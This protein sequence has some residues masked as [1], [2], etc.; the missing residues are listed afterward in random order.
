LAAL[1]IVYVLGGGDGFNQKARDLKVLEKDVCIFCDSD[2]D[3]K[4]GDPDKEKL[5]GMGICIFDCEIGNNIEKQVIS[6]LPW[7]GV[8]ELY[9]YIKK[10]KKIN[11]FDEYIEQSSG[12]NFTNSDD[13]DSREAF[14]LA[15][16]KEGN[17]FFKRIDRGEFFGDICLKYKEELSGK[18]FLRKQM[19][20]IDKWIDYGR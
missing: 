8:A 2:K 12:K 17:E 11:A 18:S 10:V 9:E 4:I 15:S 7:N 20:E 14:Y 1:G 6:E 19:E 16:T 5:R 3:E 13:S